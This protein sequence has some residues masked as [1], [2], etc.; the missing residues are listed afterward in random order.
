MICPCI[1]TSIETTAGGSTASRAYVV[2]GSES[3]EVHV[4]DLQTRERLQVIDGHDG[5][6]IAVAVSSEWG[7]TRLQRLTAVGCASRHI[8]SSHWLPQAEWTETR[9][10]SFGGRVQDL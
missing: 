7:I 1:E 3:K 4:W 9:S 2:S 8:R 6:V 10:S 5:G